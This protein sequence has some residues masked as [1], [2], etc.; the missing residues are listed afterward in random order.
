[1]ATSYVLD[2]GF[3]WNAPLI[4]SAFSGAS[5]LRPLQWGLVNVETESPAWVTEFKV[6]DSIR[7]AL[8]DITSASD[9]N[10]ETV[11]STVGI[12]GGKATPERT[13]DGVS[14][15]FGNPSAPDSA[16]YPFVE[17]PAGVFTPRFTGGTNLAALV[18]QQ[19]QIPFLV[20]TTTS[21]VFNRA[22]PDWQVGRWVVGEAPG[23]D[24]YEFDATCFVELG[25]QVTVSWGEASRDFVFDPEFF[26]GGTGG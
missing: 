11:A 17:R 10:P 25:V 8:T 5:Q 21:L 3:N 6:G 24:R 23:G 2:I 9:A 4:G 13:V 14:L 7:F 20:G 19:A 26:V 22:N 1:M 18:Y 15:V 16:V 12:S